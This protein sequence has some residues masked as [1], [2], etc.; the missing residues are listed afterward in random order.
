MAVSI[1][2]LPFSFVL[3]E[4]IGNRMQNDRINEHAGVA[5]MYFD[6]FGLIAFL[7]DTTL[8]RYNTI[9][10]TENRGE[11][12]WRRLSYFG[13]LHIHRLSFFR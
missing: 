13:N 10:A 7:F 5:D 11:R 8:L 2:A 1:K 12:N 3:R 4:P 6:I 9:A